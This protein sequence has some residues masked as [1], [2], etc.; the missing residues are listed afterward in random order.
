[1]SQTL[2]LDAQNLLKRLRDLPDWPDAVGVAGLM[3][4]V[5]R[6][7]QAAGIARDARMPLEVELLAALLGAVLQL[8]GGRPNGP[9]T[10]AA[11][12]ALERVRRE[13]P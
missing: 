3:E 13:Y 2:D 11:E 12:K 10:D 8:P 1:M 6:L 7:E 9:A 4:R 5:Q